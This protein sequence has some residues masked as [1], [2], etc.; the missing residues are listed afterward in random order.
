MSNSALIE[1]LAIAH[2]EA[3]A[4]LDARQARELEARQAYLAAVAELAQ[5]GDALAFEDMHQCRAAYCQAVRL[6]KQAMDAVANAVLC[7]P[8]EKGIA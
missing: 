2:R 4:I 3:M 7:N 8:V 1:S 5:T 6:V